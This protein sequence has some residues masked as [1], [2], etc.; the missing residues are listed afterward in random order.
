MKATSRPIAPGARIY[1]C[2]LRHVRR[3]PLRNE[4]TYRTVL[5]LIDLDH[6]PHLP[7]PA[8]LLA[9]F[10]S[11][12]HLGDPRL[13]LRRN[14]DAYL[15]AEGVDLDGGRVLMLTAPR[16]F[17]HV[18]NPLTV[19]WCHDAAGTLA[20]VIAEVHNTYGGR[21]RYLLRPDE[22]GRAAADKVFYVSP[23]Y[24]A[25]GS[26]RMSLPEPGEHLDLSIRYQPP[27]SAPFTA[28]LRG[29]GAPASLRAVLRHAWRQPCPTLLTAARIRMQGIRLYLRGLP[30]TPRQN[31]ATR[32]R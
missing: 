5:W 19:Y 32:P 16:A 18:F 23:F 11:A 24:P 21:H 9:G 20:C 28:V 17:G 25:A 27:D 1:A 8:R 14:V 6:V 26:Y 10:R 4:F 29:V 3:A 31:T 2:V 7:G 12:D 13:S 30:V 15:R 22:A